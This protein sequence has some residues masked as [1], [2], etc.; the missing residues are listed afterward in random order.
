MSDLPEP[1]TPS[2]CDLRGYDYMP[3]FG[4]KLFSSTFD[5]K[6][7]DAEF[8]AAMRL[9]WSAYAEE[10][11]AASLPDD[12][13]VLCKAAG[14]GRDNMKAWRKVKERALHGF[15]KCSDGRLYHVALSEEAV[16]NYALRLKNDAK[17]DADRERLRVWREAQKKRAAQG[18]GN[19]TG[20][21]DE[22]RF[23]TSYE[24]L[25]G[26][27]VETPNVAVE[28]K[29]R[30]EK[31]RKEN[32]PKPPRG[33]RAK[34]L[35]EDADFTAFY[36][37]YPVHDAPDDA[38][39]AWRQVTRAGALAADIMAGLARYQFRSD[40]QFI[41]APGAWLRAGCWKALAPTV[42]PQ[43]P[44][45]KFAWLDA[46]TQTPTP[47]FDLEASADVNGTFHPR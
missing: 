28:E 40:P 25:T 23:N 13:D 31:R 12:D 22:T 5:A 10:C 24:T 16:K 6:A 42:P 21:S 15:I 39:K 17:R 7:T 33:L 43:Q 32:T 18:D 38:L 9:W 36:A 34:V 1:L 19:D 4:H 11:P 2:Y 47:E 41:K 37:S 14:F 20:N 46:P 44:S 8:R 45:D 35:A 30:E 29:K 26:T 3:L 27:R